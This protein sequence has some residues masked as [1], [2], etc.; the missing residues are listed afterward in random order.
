VTALRHRQ[1]RQEA[2][3]RVFEHSVTGRDLVFTTALGTPV[4]PRYFF[5]SYMA[6]IKKEGVRQ[7]TVPATPISR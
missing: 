6:Q 1:S 5:R 4:E 7:I 2:A 3:H